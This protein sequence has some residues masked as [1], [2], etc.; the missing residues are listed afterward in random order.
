MTSA[1]V[2]SAPITDGRVFKRN[3]TSS[4][5]DSA[6]HAL[7]KVT[8]LTESCPSSEVRFP[9]TA[10]L[11]IGGAGAGIVAAVVVERYF[12]PE[13]RGA[14]ALFY[15]Q[16]ERTRVSVVGVLVLLSR[17]HL[18]YRR[19]GLDRRRVDLLIALRSKSAVF[20]ALT[21]MLHWVPK[22]R[23]PGNSSWQMPQQ[24]CTVDIDVEFGRKRG[25]GRSI[26]SRGIRQAMLCINPR[27]VLFGSR[28]L[29]RRMPEWGIIV[30]R[31][32]ETSYLSVPPP[33]VLPIKEDATRHRT[34]DA[35]TSPLSRGR[36]CDDALAYSSVLRRIRTR[37]ESQDPT[38]A[39]QH[40]T[41]KRTDSRG[42]FSN[43]PRRT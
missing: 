33:P 12:I 27:Q 41:R 26:F 37:H 32:H 38:S 8:N 11:S 5:N 14:E 20:A 19:W 10:Y 4:R 17:P 25:K 36:V 9:P 7:D 43:L 42:P 6:S 34:H 29:P 18:R 15:K 3:A 22:Y 35:S 13:G 1:H 30:T 16:C 23:N 31:G 40:D 21:S 39:S 28:T 24:I 2:V